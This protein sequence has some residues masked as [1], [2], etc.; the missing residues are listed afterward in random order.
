MRLFLRR[1]KLVSAVRTSCVPGGDQ[2][3]TFRTLFGR[4]WAMSWEGRILHSHLVDRTV[5]FDVAAEVQDEAV[6]FPRMQAETPTH[7]LHKQPRRHRRPEQSNA[8]DIR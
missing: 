1:R 3:M 2:R 7:H 6:A 8:I 4:R 5:P